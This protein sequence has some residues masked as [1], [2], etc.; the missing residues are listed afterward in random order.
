LKEKKRKNKQLWLVWESICIE[1]EKGVGKEK[2]AT[3]QTRRKKDLG[4][5]ACLLAGIKDVP[6]QPNK[7]RL[8]EFQIFGVVTTYLKLVQFEI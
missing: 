4:A 2:I 5:H 7:Q 6:N 8:G 1:K 3:N